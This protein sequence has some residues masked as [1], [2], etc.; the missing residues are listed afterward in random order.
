M[1]SVLFVLVSDMSLISFYSSLVEQEDNGMPI[2]LKGGS[3]DT[4]LYRTTMALTVFGAGYVV[5]GLVSAA[6]PKKPQ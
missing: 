4:L 3:K 6:V 5:Y 2:H 1:E